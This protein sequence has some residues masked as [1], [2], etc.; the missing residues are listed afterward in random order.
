MLSD[1]ADEF[2]IDAH[3]L[4][5]SFQFAMDQP[6][7]IFG[8][9]TDMKRSTP[10]IVIPQSSMEEDMRRIRDELQQVRMENQAMRSRLSRP[11]TATTSTIDREEFNSLRREIERLGDQSRQ[12]TPTPSSI[13]S[14]GKLLPGRYNGEADFEDYLAQF[15][16]VATA[17]AWSDAEKAAVLLGRLEG[18]ALSAV[19]RGPDMQYTTM[20]G[21]LLK[22]F[23]MDHEETYA[24]RLQTLVK[25]DD[26]TWEDLAHEVRLLASKG[27]KDVGENTQNRLA[28]QGFINAVTDDKTREKLRDRNPKSVDEAVQ[29]AHQV[30]CNLTLEKVRQKTIETSSE[31]KKKKSTTQARKVEEEKASEKDPR[32]QALEDKVAQ[33]QEEL[34]K[35]NVTPGKQTS[36]PQKNQQSRPRRD[37]IICYSCRLPGH[38]RRRCPYRNNPQT[39]FPSVRGQMPSS[40]GYPVSVA[41]P[42]TAPSSSPSSVSS[43]QPTPLSYEIPQFSPVQQSGNFQGQP[44]YQ[45]AVGFLPKTPM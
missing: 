11:T 9:Q 45:T 19:S 22:Q 41:P 2:L 3:R 26:Q 25:K 42:S 5:N 28:V 20:I 27:Y 6:G 33:L 39:S 13:F 21:R 37:D 32:L 35:V 14:S 10:K 16:V 38:I 17:N 8:E 30:E 31:E 43:N 7:D 12:A 29:M 23:S 40:A 18:K 34:N 15:T 24:Q 1:E 44:Q 4:L 36:K